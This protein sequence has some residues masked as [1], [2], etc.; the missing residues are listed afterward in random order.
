MVRG[1]GGGKQKRRKVERVTERCR[2][3]RRKGRGGEKEGE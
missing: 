2:D 1:K 3:N